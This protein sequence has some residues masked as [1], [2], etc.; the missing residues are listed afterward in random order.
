MDPVP[1]TMSVKRERSIKG[2]LWRGNKEKFCQGLPELLTDSLPGKCGDAGFSRWI[3]DSR[4]EPGN[5]TP[6]NRLSYFRGWGMGALECEPV[7]FEGRESESVDV[8]KLY[9]LA[10]NILDQREKVVLSGE[11][12]RLLESFVKPGISAG[13]TIS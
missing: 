1:F 7:R 5:I 11:E 2:L 10:R 9:S 13:R 4:I 3:E 12:S 8:L 6:V